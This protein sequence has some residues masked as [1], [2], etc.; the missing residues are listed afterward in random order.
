MRQVPYPSPGEILMHEFLVPMGIST[1]ELAFY[2][3]LSEEDV[4][5]IIGGSLEISSDRGQRLSRFFGT[6][7]GFWMGLQ[8]DFNKTVG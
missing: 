8:S 4:Q 1:A 2:T 7:D 3:G 5:R 6:S